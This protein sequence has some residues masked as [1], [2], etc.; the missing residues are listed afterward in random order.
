VR[1]LGLLVR[2]QKNMPK[3]REAVQESTH[4]ID[5][6]HHF[7]ATLGNPISRSNCW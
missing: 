6:Y 1:Q 4:A 2:V 7:N 3:A 5:A